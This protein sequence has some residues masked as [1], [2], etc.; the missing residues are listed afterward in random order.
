MEHEQMYERTCIYGINIA[1]LEMASP[2]NSEISLKSMH[3]VSRLVYHT[4]RPSLNYL[5]G[6]T[7]EIIC[8]DHAY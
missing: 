3:L 5:K 6:V 4:F 7:F 1:S 2:E 8:C